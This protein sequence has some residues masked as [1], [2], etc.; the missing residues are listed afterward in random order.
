M[1]R[2]ALFK[3]IDDLAA[4]DWQPGRVGT[5][6]KLEEGAEPAMLAAL[7]RKRGIILHIARDDAKAEELRAG[8]SFFRS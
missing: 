5:I 8:L 4:A 1:A 6:C 3:Q 7:A 2:P